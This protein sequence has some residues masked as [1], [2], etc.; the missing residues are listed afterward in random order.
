MEETAFV[1]GLKRDT[2]AT[3]NGGEAERREED[4]KQCE[5]QEEGTVQL[6]QLFLK[7]SIRECIRLKGEI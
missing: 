5:I 4:A 6:S 1:T 3:A 7:L 2:P